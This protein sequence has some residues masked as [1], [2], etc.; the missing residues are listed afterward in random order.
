M[1]LNAP[2]AKRQS[3]DFLQVPLPQLVLTLPDGKKAHA[4]VIGWLP[5]PDFTHLLIRHASTSPPQTPLP[6][7]NWSAHMNNH[8]DSTPDPVY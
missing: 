2:K 1:D 8:S 6:T 4:A 7:D 3:I 5:A